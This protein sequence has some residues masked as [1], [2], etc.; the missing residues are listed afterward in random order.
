MSLSALPRETLSL[1]SPLAS[2]SKEL[3]LSSS[4]IEYILSP[5]GTR[6]VSPALVQR[7]V[8]PYSCLRGMY[9]LQS[10]KLALR[11]F[12]ELRAGEVHRGSP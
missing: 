11:N 6:I 7:T 8:A 9:V 1:A 3:A 10:T 12:R 4:F 2:S 5:K